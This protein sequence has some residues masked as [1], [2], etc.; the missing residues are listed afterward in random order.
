MVVRRG[1]DGRGVGRGEREVLLL[2][3]LLSVLRLLLRMGNAGSLLREL[4]KE[5]GA[6]VGRE[7]AVGTGVA[8][9]RVGADTG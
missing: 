9:H 6:E 2:L 8:V 7:I 5:G 4:A 3:L 1:G